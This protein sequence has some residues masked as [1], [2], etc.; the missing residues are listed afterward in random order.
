MESKLTRQ[1]PDT[2][3][4]KVAAKWSG[5]LGSVRGQSCRAGGGRGLPSMSPD[6]AGRVCKRVG[7]VSGPG[8]GTV[9]WP[10]RVSRLAGGKHTALSGLA[11]AAVPTQS[12][13]LCSGPRA[14][15][16]QDAT[17]GFPSS[18]YSPG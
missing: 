3:G 4:G 18:N 12:T 2:V 5:L 13:Q 17:M 11:K 6:Q 16:C 1:D 10:G 14:R 9:A 8:L 15:V 7:I